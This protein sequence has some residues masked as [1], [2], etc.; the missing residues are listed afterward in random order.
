MK[1]CPK[2]QAEL[3]DTVK[4]C[5]KCG[6]KIE[7]ASTE[8]A[9]AAEEAPHKVC[10]QCQAQADVSAK[11]CKKCGYRF[12][13]KSESEQKPPKTNTNPERKRSGKPMVIGA[14]LVLLVAVVFAAVWFLKNGDQAS[15]HYAETTAGEMTTA[16]E[17]E[18]ETEAE[19]VAE[20]DAEPETEAAETTAAPA[21]TAESS[22]PF[23][24]AYIFP[25]SSIRY[26]EY[27]E[28]QGLSAEELRL[29]RNE[30]Y[31]RHGRI[32]QDETLKTYFESKSWYTPQVPA[33]QFSDDAMLSQIERDNIRLIQDVEAGTPAPAETTGQTGSYR[34]ATMYVANCQ[35]SI[36][37]R[38]SA[39]TKAEEIRQIPLGAAVSYIEEAGN[40]FYKVAYMGNTGYALAS[41]LEGYEPQDWDPYTTVYVV[42][43]QESITLRKSPSTKA[44]E[45]RQI[46]LGEPV[47][48]RKAVEDGFS[49]IEY[50]NEIGY[51]LTSYLAY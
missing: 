29:A 11:F 19:T 42:N 23:Q 10:P 39:S 18:M 16:A 6:Y 22:A 27:G 51:V 7:I 33:D 49:M 31:A 44:D 9:P 48:Y 25:E 20:T 38:K 32:F 15:S 37:L 17:T 5:N 50:N 43:C 47:I 26:L 28:V 8:I 35:E 12:G 1:I 46:P 2:C 41:Y 4:F 21:E 24:D 30:I 3:K 36:T 34:Y 14:V 45:I 13:E 40:G